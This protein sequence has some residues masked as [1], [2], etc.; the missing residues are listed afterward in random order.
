MLDT[1]HALDT[2]EGLHV[3]HASGVVLRQQGVAVLA[4][5]HVSFCLLFGACDFCV[6]QL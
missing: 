1:R 4:G 2:S 6:H 5:V 3:C